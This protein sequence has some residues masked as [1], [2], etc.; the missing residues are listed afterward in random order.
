M[1]KNVQSVERVLDLIEVIASMPDGARHKDIEAKLD[2]PKST[3]NRLL[4]TLC[5]RGYLE[6]NN[7]T[8]RYRISHNLVC[9]ASQYLSNLDVRVVASQHIK[10]LSNKLNVT[11]H[12][13]IE[14]NNKAVYVEKFQPYSYACMFSAVGK[15]I[16][17][18]C[19]ALGKAFL[20][21]YG[22]NELSNYINNIDYI[23]FTKNTI[24]NSQ[25]L[26]K[27][28]DIA[29]N[30][31]ITKDNA[32]HEENVYCI[33][34]PIYDYQNKI[35]AAISISSD[36]KEKIFSEQYKNELLEC[37]KNISAIFGKN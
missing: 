31:C 15:S 33:A 16:D 25:D 6:K 13:A 18:Y 19:S 28:L 3:I 24:I 14:S 22:Q 11:S 34:S 27:E 29:K 2:L 37:A 36:N 7:D 20:I 21:G 8:K 35:I 9:L 5:N 32:E 30:E 17:L 23:K 4:S 26:I 10:A 1:V 12:L